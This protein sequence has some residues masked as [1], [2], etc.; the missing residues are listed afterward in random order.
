VSF[1]SNYGKGQG[2][3]HIAQQFEDGRQYSV[4]FDFSPYLNAN[5]N[6]KI[7]TTRE[8]GFYCEGDDTL[9]VALVENVDEDD[10]VCLR[11]APDCIIIAYRNDELIQ[12]GDRV[13]IRMSKDEFI[14][15]WIG[16]G[17]IVR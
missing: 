17:E 2:I 8:A 13:E 15:T 14:I 11:I 4:E 16:V 5:E 7:G 10:E 1:T 12:E 6:T 3:G 9:I